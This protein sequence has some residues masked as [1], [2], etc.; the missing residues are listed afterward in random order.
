METILDLQLNE[1][2][3]R[4]YQVL[5]GRTHPEMKMNAC[6]GYL[7]SGI[8]VPAPTPQTT[9]IL[10]KPIS[11]NSSDTSIEQS[12]SNKRQKIKNN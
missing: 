11:T 6:S 10:P 7:L 9:D 5:P 12:L 3:T 8:K 4:E 1:T 2:W